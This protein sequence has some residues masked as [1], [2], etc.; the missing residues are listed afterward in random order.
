MDFLLK[1]VPSCCSSSLSHSCPYVCP[2]PP[3]HSHFRVGRSWRVKKVHFTICLSLEI[4]STE[5]SS[6]CV[7]YSCRFFCW[8]GG[9]SYWW[10][11][12]E[13]QGRAAR[14][15]PAVQTQPE[16]LLLETQELMVMAW[17]TQRKLLGQNSP[18]TPCSCQQH[19]FAC[20]I[21][22]ASQTSSLYCLEQYFWKKH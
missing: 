10:R 19:P 22:E 4:C 7:M 1:L 6:S 18:K 14:E 13:S 16:P 21:Q 17:T 20:I 3:L 12:W 15:A 5:R 8:N 2:T 9:G 11:N